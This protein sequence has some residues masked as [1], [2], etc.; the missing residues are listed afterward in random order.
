MSRWDVIVMIIY[1]IYIYFFFFAYVHVI[2]SPLSSGALVELCVYFCI[3]I[4]IIIIKL[5]RFSWFSKS[6]GHWP[7]TSYSLFC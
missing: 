4:I 2:S 5:Q 7:G 3:I 1:I 6:T